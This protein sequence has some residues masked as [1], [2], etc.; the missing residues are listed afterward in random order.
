MQMVRAETRKEAAV[1]CL[2]MVTSVPIDTVRAR[3]RSTPGAWNINH[4]VSGK[5]MKALLRSFRKPV[6]YTSR[7]QVKPEG[8][9]IVSTWTNGEQRRR[10]VVWCDGSVYDPVDCMVAGSMAA[11]LQ[12]MD[13][14]AGF[15]FWVDATAVHGT[16]SCYSNHKCRCRECRVAWT[17]YCKGNR[18]RRVAEG[19]CIQCW[20]AR[21]PYHVRCQ[22]HHGRMQRKNKTKRETR[23]GP[24]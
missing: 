22:L 5:S 23:R 8:I 18:Q 15:W 10:W 4:G 17:N 12:A 21:L 7:T 3:V 19:L 11:Y 20:R 13:A 16:P 9:A 14:H 2:A 6:R 24:R 1:A